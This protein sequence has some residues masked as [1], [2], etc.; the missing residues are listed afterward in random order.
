ME[1][2]FATRFV[3]FSFK[4]TTMPMECQLLLNKASDSKSSLRA[5]VV[6]TTWIIA[7]VSSFSVF[8]QSTI[9]SAI[10]NSSLASIPITSSLSTI[11]V[12]RYD[13]HGN[14]VLDLSTVDQVLRDAIGTNV[15]VPQIRRALVKLREA[16]R[17]QGY[18]Q[19]VISLPRQLLTNGTV[20]ILVREGSSTLADAA[21]FAAKT[22]AIPASPPAPARTFEVRQYE[23]AGNSLL[24]P[25]VIDQVLSPFTGTNVS[26]MQIQKAL[27]EL[28][29]AYRERGYATV[30]VGLPQQQLTNAIVKVQVTEGKLV[31][32][33]VTGNRFFS[34]NNVMSALPSLQTNVI[35]NSRIFQ[36]ELDLANQNRDRQIYPTI[37]PGPDP[38]TS[39]LNLKVKD[40]LP[41]HGRL[42][43]NNYST[44]GTPDWRI[45]TSLSYNNLWQHEHQLG[46]S[47]GFTPEAFKTDGIT[48][49]FLLNRPLVAN[50]GAYYRLPFGTPSSVQQQVNSSRQFG[51]DEATRQ[52]RL[53]PA[54]VRPDLTIFASSS[55]SDTGVKLGPARIVSRTPLLTIISQDSGQNLT[56]NESAGGRLNIPLSLSDT[57]RLS[58]SGGLD[59]K[60]YSLE[61]YNSNNFIITTVITNAQGS[62]TIDSQVA[63]PQPVRSAELVYL[64]L[65]LGVDYSQSDPGGT[66]V[67]SLGF[68][69]NFL[70][71]ST[72]F[73]MQSYSRHAD[74]NF[75]KATLSLTRDQ[76][77]FSNW[78]LLLRASGQAA[79]G[80]LISNEQFALGGLNSVRGYYEGDEYG[81]SGWSGS[82]ELRTPYIASQ[83]PLWTESAPAW[84][85]GVAFVEGGQRFAMAKAFS[86]DPS[87]SLLGVGFGVSANLNNHLDMRI[88]VGWPLLN[89]FNT[90]A[91]DPR[92]HFSV[93][94]QF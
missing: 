37:S 86:R 84:L 14:T 70:G 92:A 33:R 18:N 89:S 55:S 40:R 69:Y 93:G 68:S 5:A 36:R 11:Q 51:Y 94:G 48:S 27:G 21:A 60:R 54:G 91:G 23:V 57:R 83:V 67:A 31:D 80:P 76:K 44:P 72:N 50:L 41:L 17:D 35:L 88:A 4:N 42:E 49:D 56:I 53:P 74:A 39:A 52:F 22:N 10:T 77:L 59:A 32:I 46:L 78:S 25:E 38:G 28:Q 45:N 66:L 6:V 47:Y 82:V 13:I 62:Q 63:S 43:V 29:L 85:R 16:Y 90:A 61:S 20:S 87:N 26:L 64:P 12:Q 71:D 24:K 19:V 1:V 3:S 58:F 9:Q 65:S 75:G 79:T 73:A 30:S 15:T 7:M 2:F 8:G 81:D 34:S